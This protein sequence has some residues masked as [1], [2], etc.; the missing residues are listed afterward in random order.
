MVYAECYLTLFDMYRR[1]A[2]GWPPV[3]WGVVPLSRAQPCFSLLY[4]LSTKTPPI[5][6]CACCTRPF[7]CPGH[8]LPSQTHAL[9]LFFLSRLTA[10]AIL[11]DR[12][13]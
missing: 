10:L 1:T 13:L 9:H 3:S 6:T 12:Q 8:D 11:N 7:P 4:Y 2:G 5:Y